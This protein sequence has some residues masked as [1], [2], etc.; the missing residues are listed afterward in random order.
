MTQWPLK[1]A[2]EHFAEVISAAQNAPQILTDG[3]ETVAVVLGR[4]EYARLTGAAAQVKTRKTV[5]YK[6]KEMDLVDLLLARPHK[7]GF[8]FERAPAPEPRDVEF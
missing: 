1:D 2:N 8:E 3:I 5:L 4:E 6:G 7:E